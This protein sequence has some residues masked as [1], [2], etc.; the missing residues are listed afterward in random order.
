MQPSLSQ[1]TGHE[2]T[3]DV[4]PKRSGRA[5]GIVDA[6]IFYGVIVLIVLTAIPYGTVAPWSQATFE[7]VVFVL[8]LLWIVHG[9][10]SGSWGIG[11]TS[12][13]LPL[14]ALIVLAI[15]QSFVWWQVDWAGTRVGYS[16][17]ADPFESWLFVL[18]TGA[19]TLTALLLIRF[20]S[21]R[22][23][24]EI[25]IHSIIV[26]AVASALFGIIRQ[27]IQHAPGF[28]L[29]A[30]KPAIGYGQ[31]INRNHFAF[32]MEMAI[33]LVVGLLVMRSRRRER[34]PFYLAALMALWAALVLSQSRGGVMAMAAQ[35][36]FAAL[37]FVN[38]RRTRESGDEESKPARLGWLRSLP[39]KVIMA[40]ALLAIII[41]GIGWLGGDQL[42]SGVETAA[43]ELAGVD[44]TELH[45][46]ARRRDIWRASWLMFR[47][48]PILGAGLGGYWAEVPN[49]HQASGVTTPQQAHNDYLELLASAGVAG[50]AL[51]VWFVLALVKQ[52]R[53]NVRAGEG[54]QR[55]AS[56]GAIVGL[57]GVSVHS[58]VDFGLHITVNGL[59]FVAL[60]AIISLDRIPH[61]SGD[62]RKPARKMFDNE[63]RQAVQAHQTTAFK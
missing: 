18:R 45:E 41:A 48:H 42:A 27:A 61:E 20:T 31:F 51:L 54:L 5:L 4:S 14:V 63:K 43:V 55:A 56:L 39:V 8:T 36:V 33:G 40:G 3:A 46:G 25:L 50:A 49:Y 30:L 16:L 29:P 44:R 38:L 62:R 1:D 37:L 34:I 10:L 35:V 60:L 6:A 57:T 53:Q 12:V 19:L 22:R 15:V 2:F 26:V 28:V 17:S 11:K 7:V 13:I 32:L 23:R 52:A 9:L 24:L 58:L 59:V 47:A 21:S